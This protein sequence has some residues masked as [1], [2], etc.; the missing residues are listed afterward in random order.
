MLLGIRALVWLVYAYLLITEVVL[1]LGF[2]LLLFGA[3][4]DASFV[5]WV[6]RS[7]DRAMEPFRGMFTP[8]DLGLSGNQNVGA[9][10]DT[11]VLFAMLVY[12][13]GAWA[14]HTALEWLGRLIERDERAAAARVYAPAP[15]PPG[16]G[17][18]GS[19]APGS[20]AA[21]HPTYAPP[22]SP[23]PPTR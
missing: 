20:G 13:F 22:G 6:Y 16:A 4:P 19:G 10:L 17:G 18:P 15:L 3:N 23:P 2:V 11:S 21:G 14:V 5:A 12:A 1:T 9:V 7:L 8:I